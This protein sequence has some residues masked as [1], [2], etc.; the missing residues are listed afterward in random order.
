MTSVRLA[1]TIVILTWATV[2]LAHGGNANQAPWD[3]CQAMNVGDSCEFTDHHGDLHRGTCRAFDGEKMCLRHQP[4]VHTS[5]KRA[6]ND[7]IKDYQ[8]VSIAVISGICGIS[9]TA[10]LAVFIR[11]RTQGFIHDKNR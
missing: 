11:N 9:I 3:V 10:F 5:A 2:A 1:V 4:I 8:S 7:N 6:A